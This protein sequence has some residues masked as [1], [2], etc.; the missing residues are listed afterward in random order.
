MAGDR[1]LAPGA[2]I[3]TLPFRGQYFRVEQ[4]SGESGSAKEIAAGH[5]V[6]LDGEGTIGGQRYEPRQVWRISAPTEWHSACATQ[7]L[8]VNT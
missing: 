3:V 4:V 8:L 1:G 7:T 5:W 6:V 2:G